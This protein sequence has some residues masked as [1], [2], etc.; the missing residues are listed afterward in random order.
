[1]RAQNSWHP[2]PSSPEVRQRAEDY[3]GSQLGER[4]R[5]SIA[6]DMDFFIVDRQGISD[7]PVA[8]S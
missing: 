2:V 3:L 6:D 7:T 1:M 8:D 4:H 5:A